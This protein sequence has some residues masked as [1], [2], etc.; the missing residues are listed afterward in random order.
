MKSINLIPFKKPQSIYRVID[1]QA[2]VITLQ[3]TKKKKDKINI[4]NETGTRIWELIDG[5]KSIGDIHNRIAKE[6]SI[7]KKKIRLKVDDFFL[8]MK[9]NDLINFKTKS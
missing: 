1:G 9:N 6:Y 5:K 4:F 8:K 7:S 2:I 3:K